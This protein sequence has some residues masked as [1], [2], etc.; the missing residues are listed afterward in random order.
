MNDATPLPERSLQQE[1]KSAADHIYFIGT[2]I[3]FLAGHKPGDHKI[4]WPVSLTKTLRV[5]NRGD[6]VGHDTAYQARQHLAVAAL[7]SGTWHIMVASTAFVTVWDRL[8]P[9][10]PA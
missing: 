2:L 6:N 5:L 7:S 8:P 10:G 4:S 3:S 9:L 1:D